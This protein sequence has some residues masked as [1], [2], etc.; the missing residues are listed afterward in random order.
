MSNDLVILDTCSKIELA[1][2]TDVCQCCRR[3]GEALGQHYFSD[4][5]QYA[6]CDQ[7]QC[8]VDEQV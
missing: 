5:F 3:V 6:V 1:W 8:L 2:R 4:Y 7:H